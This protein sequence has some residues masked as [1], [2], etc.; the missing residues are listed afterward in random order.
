MM[1]RLFYII[2]YRQNKCSILVYIK[3]TSKNGHDLEFVMA[4]D[5]QV[6]WNNGFFL[7]LL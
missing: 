7:L 4:T 6:F 5:E 1:F 3:I 2:V